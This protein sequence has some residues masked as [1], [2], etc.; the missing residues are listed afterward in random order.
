ICYSLPDGQ[1]APGCQ[2]PQ[3]GPDAIALSLASGTARDGVWQGWVAVP[4]AAASGTWTLQSLTVFAGDGRCA[5]GST[6]I[7][8]GGN[9]TV[10]GTTDMTPPTIFPPTIS[11]TTVGLGGTV[12][13][14]ARI[15]DD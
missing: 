5:C 8:A 9:F 10:L 15:T 14:S 13:I 4:P 2:G 7:L 6:S 12:T 11:P 1:A 3:I